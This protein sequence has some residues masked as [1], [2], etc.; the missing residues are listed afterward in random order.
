MGSKL[1]RTDKLVF[2]Q[3]HC[4]AVKVC[5]KVQVFNAF[6]YAKLKIFQKFH[7]TEKTEKIL[8]IIILEIFKCVFQIPGK[9]LS[10]ILVRR[11]F[12]CLVTI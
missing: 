11:M 1:R 3:A 9:I 10:E 7:I 4:I 8:P 6:L 12:W 5:E 2:F